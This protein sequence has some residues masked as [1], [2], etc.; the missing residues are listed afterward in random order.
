MVLKFRIQSTLSTVMLIIIIRP[1]VKR[2]L[3]IIQ[4]T[5]KRLLV[6]KNHDLFQLALMAD[7]ASVFLSCGEDAV[8]FELDVRSGTPNKLVLHCFH[9]FNCLLIVFLGL[10]GAI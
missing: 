5:Y 9:V 3:N 6:E 10:R 7:C 2:F 4:K 1:S 8:V